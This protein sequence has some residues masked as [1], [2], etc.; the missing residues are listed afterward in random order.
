[1]KVIFLTDVKGKGKR[2][3]VK[4]MSNGY[5][6][7][8]LIKNKLAVEATSANIKALEEENA[9]SSKLEEV[10]LNEMKALAKQI[11]GV[12]LNFEL[13]T[14]SKSGSVFGSVSSKQIRKELENAGYKVDAH[15]IILDNAINNLGYTDV[16]VKIYKNITAMIKVHVVGS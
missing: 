7:N 13:K 16:E 5:A 9:R 4:E 12:E 1:M 14:D 15:A 6:Q 3:D 2:G 10:K 11:E 8:F